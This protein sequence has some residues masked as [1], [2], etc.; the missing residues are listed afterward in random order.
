MRP[1]SAEV[2]MSPHE[3]TSVPNVRSSFER[4]SKTANS[5]N[6]ASDRLNEALEQLNAALKKLNLGIS[7]WVSFSTWE[8]G[9]ASEVEQIG[10]D[11]IKGKWGIGL[12]KVYE[13]LNSSD[14]STGQPFLEETEWHFSEAPR[15]MRLRAIDHL[16][17]MIDKLD[18][19]AEKA[20]QSIGLKT[21]EAEAFAAAIS[22]IVDERPSRK[23]PI[24]PVMG[25][26]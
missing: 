25:G 9:G 6:L 11:K 26:K 23:L 5:L 22:S 13:D 3:G 18:V 4:L 17:L 19:D 20:T 2:I 7:S 12:R 1:Y 10:Y 21:A 16:N 15:E 14:P 24:R 8:D